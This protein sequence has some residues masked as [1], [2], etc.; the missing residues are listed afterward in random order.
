[1][2]VGDL[3]RYKHDQNKTGLVAQIDS[4]R[5][6]SLLVLWLHQA[7]HGKRQWYVQ[8]SWVEVISASR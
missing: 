7:D 6:D 3:I 5:V 1:M 4:K 8:P 2:K